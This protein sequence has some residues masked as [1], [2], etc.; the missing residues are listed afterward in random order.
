MKIYFGAS[1]SLDRSLLP[2]YQEIVK[3]VKKLGHKVLSEDVVDPKLKVGKN[4]SPQ[5]LFERE[6]KEIKR[7]DLMIAE[8]TVPSWGTAFLME[9][10]LKHQKP[11]LALYYKDNGYKLPIMLE[12]HP[13]LY[14]QSYDED[15]LDTVLNFNLKHFQLR[16]KRKGKLI[17][18]DGTNG[19]GKATQTKMLLNYLKKHKVKSNYISFPRY[20]TS[21]HGKTVGR[22]LNGEFGKL[23]DVSPYLSSLAYALDRLTSKNEILDW[24]DDNHIVV[25]DRY[26]TSS[27]AHQ[28]AK[29]ADKDRSKFISWLYDMEYKQHRMPKEN[30]VIFLYVPP[31]IS[32]KL[33]LKKAKKYKHGRK[34]DIEEGLNYQKKVFKLY[35]KLCKKYKHWVAIKCVDNKGKLRSRQK[36][37]ADIISQLKKAKIL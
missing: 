1:I 20:Y 13:E 19:S 21:F 10:A 37:N 29:L 27:F 4:L 8:V 6:S 22:F 24:L 23:E 11:I 9:Q 35:L 34:K 7:A 5:K 32:D 33:I 17:V 12:G 31:E 15:N 3:I 28:G 2:K 16:L 36:I 30:I 25:A 18:I 14:V 26:I